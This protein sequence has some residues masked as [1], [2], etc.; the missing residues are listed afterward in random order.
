MPSVGCCARGDSHR[1]H[2]DHV[3]GL[4]Q[5]ITSHRHHSRHAGFLG[6]QA[7]RV[8]PG[9]LGIIP[10]T[11]A[12]EKVR[13]ARALSAGYRSGVRALPYRLGRQAALKFG[14]WRVRM[15]RYSPVDVIGGIPKPRFG[16][17]N[18]SLQHVGRFAAM[19]HQEHA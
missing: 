12:P 1:A 11:D 18:D 4:V 16:D 13:E 14:L 2:A 17:C 15:G 6:R 8:L 5:G 7:A 9:H 10:D 3:V 19:H